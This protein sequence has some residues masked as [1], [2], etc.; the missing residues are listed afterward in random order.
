MNANRPEA[1]ERSLSRRNVL[2]LMGLGA[3]SATIPAVLHGCTNR[4]Q[5]QASPDRINGDPCAGTIAGSPASA[6]SKV[7]ARACRS[8]Q[9]K[10][11]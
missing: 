7:R 11:K 3:A 4:V 1:T 2:Q 9:S 5:G 8:E 6:S 10:D